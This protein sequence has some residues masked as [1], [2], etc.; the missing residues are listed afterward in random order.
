MEDDTISTPEPTAP[1]DTQLDTTAELELERLKKEVEEWKGKYLH[2]L[3]EGENSRKRLQKERQEMIQHAMQKVIVE[4]LNPI[5]QLENALGYADQAAPEIKNWAIGFQM[6]ANQFKEVL[7]SHGVK[8][9]ESEGQ[10]FDPHYHEAVEVVTT[11][12]HPHNTVIKQHIRGY[13]MGGQRV[14]RPARVHVSRAPQPSAEEP[15][16]AD[17]DE[18]DSTNHIHA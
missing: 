5:D 4:F 14:I 18:T 15:I 6:I 17:Q 7:N 2:A 1:Q 10:P 12:D 9:F 16:P 3:A 11:G 13:T 8:P